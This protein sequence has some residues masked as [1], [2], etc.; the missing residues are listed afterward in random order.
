M[1]IRIVITSTHGE[2]TEYPEVRCCGV[3]D[4]LRGVDDVLFDGVTDVSTAHFFFIN[5]PK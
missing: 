3:I 4:S 5:L 2:D 1:Y